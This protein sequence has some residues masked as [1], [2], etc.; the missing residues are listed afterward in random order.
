MDTCGTGGSGLN[1]FNV[2]TATAFVVSAAG[3]KLAKH[4]NRAMS[5][6]CGSADVLE[7]LGI[8]IEVSAQVTEK[9]IKE[10]GLGFL[11]LLYITQL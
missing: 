5:S 2:S 7:E 11:M 4:G 1:K 6:N 10:T 8:N 9:A 3:V